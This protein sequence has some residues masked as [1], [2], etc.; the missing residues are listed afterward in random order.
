MNGVLKKKANLFVNIGILLEL[1]Y[2]AGLELNYAMP[3]ILQTSGL[4]LILISCVYY[5]E[6]KGYGKLTGFFLGFFG[7]I[8]WL[9]IYFLRDKTVE[10]ANA[11]ASSH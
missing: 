7:I 8:G 10:S 5:A 11:I 4:V 3:A 1:M 6:S 2:F 9:F